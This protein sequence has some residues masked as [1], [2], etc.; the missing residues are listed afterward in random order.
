MTDVLDCLP[1]WEGT[2]LCAGRPD[3]MADPETAMATCL[4]GARGGGPCPVLAACRTWVLSIPVHEGPDGV[5]AGM[6]F[7]ERERIIL[8]RLP[9]QECVDCHEVKPLYEFAQNTE[10]KPNRRLCC[11]PCMHRRTTK[12]RRGNR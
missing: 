10:G 3:R 1:I 5:V 8:G 2:G 11:K 7:A 4:T 6:S 12:A 9:P